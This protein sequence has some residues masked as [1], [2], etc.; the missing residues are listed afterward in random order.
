MKLKQNEIAV[1]NDLGEIIV[2]KITHKGEKGAD[3]G[4]GYIR[5]APSISR[6][7]AKNTGTKSG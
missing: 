6:P 5:H 2:V 4:K 7:V 3:W 1:R